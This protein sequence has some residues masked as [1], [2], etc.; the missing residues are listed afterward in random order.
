LFCYVNF[1]ASKDLPSANAGLHAGQRAPDF[2]LSDA[3]GKPVNLSELLKNNRAVLLIFYR[4]Y[5]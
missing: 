5:W 1:S 2:T 3:N 4:G